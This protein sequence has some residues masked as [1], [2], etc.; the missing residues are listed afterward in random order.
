MKGFRVQKLI[1]IGFVNKNNIRKSA[2]L[3]PNYYS[4]MIAKSFLQ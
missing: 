4:K 1:N 3:W 2:L